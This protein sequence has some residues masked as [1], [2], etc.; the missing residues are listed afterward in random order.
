MY[1]RTKSDARRNAEGQRIRC[2]TCLWWFMIPSDTIGECR[3]NPPDMSAQKNTYHWP[4]TYSSDWCRCWTWNHYLKEIKDDG[5][6]T[7]ADEQAKA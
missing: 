7:Q 6:E 2:E 5:Q 1:D 3:V 4:R